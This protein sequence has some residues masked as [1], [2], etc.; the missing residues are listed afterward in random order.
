MATSVDRRDY[1]ISFNSAD[2][3]FAEALDAALR[4]EGFTTFYHPRDVGPGA[5]L[6]QLHEG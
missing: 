6:S 1:F 3:A 5:L 4:A 2:L